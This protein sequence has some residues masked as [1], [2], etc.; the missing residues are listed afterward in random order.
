ML[1]GVRAMAN[2]FC[3]SLALETL[4]GHRKSDITWWHI[5]LPASSCNVSW[6]G[7]KQDSKMYVRLYVRIPT[8][9]FALICKGRA[10]STK[11]PKYF[12]PGKNSPETR[13]GISFNSGGPE[14]ILFR[15]YVVLPPTPNSK[16]NVIKISHFL[17][18]ESKRKVGA[19]RVSGDKDFQKRSHHKK[20]L[21][22]ISM[23]SKFTSEHPR[24]ASPNQSSSEIPC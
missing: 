15:K 20:A 5:P 22:L 8:P 2:H 21:S 6:F 17:K 1:L 9:S 4:W 3:A 18:G 14:V 13:N 19:R 16:T 24:K 23:W 11:V 7:Q 10:K 12:L